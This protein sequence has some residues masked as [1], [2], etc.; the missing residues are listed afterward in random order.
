MEIDVITIFPEMFPAVL[1]SSIMK[2]SQASGRLRVGVRNLRDYTHDKRRTVDDRPYGGG[3]G[4]VMKP[5]PM[6]EAVEAIRRACGHAGS[7]ASG[8]GA[9]LNCRTILTSPQGE[10]LSPALA[11]NLAGL[12]HLIIIC[13][14]YE[15]VDERVR[16]ALVHQT[17]SIG[18]YVLTG[19]ELPALVLIDCLARFIPGVLGHALAADEDSFAAGWL[20]HPQYTRPPI[21]K[22]MAVPD[23][24]RSGDHRRIARWRKLQ[25]VTATLSSRPNLFALRIANCG[26]DDQKI[27]N[28]K[29]EIHN[30]R[31]NERH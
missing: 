29:S 1:G 30:P 11:R 4:M 5:E 14:H 28:R 19:G 24:L 27:R 12:E 23:V 6:F 3:A 26:L 31:R 22:N 10:T 16:Q 17:I 18:D 20:E 25:A 7:R 2:R 15:G 13:G 9:G 21:Y 8:D